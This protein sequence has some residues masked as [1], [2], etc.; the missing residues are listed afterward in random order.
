MKQTKRC[1]FSLRSPY[2]WLAL[3][4]LQQRASGHKSGIEFLPFFE[5]HGR[6]R[7]L[8]LEMGGECLYLPMSKEKH[9]YILSDV[10]RLMRRQ[11][12][13]PKWPAELDVDWTA[14]HC[15]YL[16]C[17]GASLKQAFVTAAMEKRWLHG[18][19]I[20]GWDAVRALLRDLT[21]HEEADFI[22]DAAQSEAT[23]SAAAAVLYQAWEDGVFGVPFLVAGREKFWGH[24]RLDM[25]MEACAA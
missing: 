12:L 3:R 19:D 7:E 17:P 15:A 20:C 23:A 9:L 18:A 6:V 10:K 4:E 8:L 25:F 16:C 11:G 1:Y 24:D 22:I 5:P 14:P 13:V 2:A 21:A